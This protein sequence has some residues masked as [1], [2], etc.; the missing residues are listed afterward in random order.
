MHVCTH[1]THQLTH[2][3]HF[4]HHFISID[5]FCTAK[6][7]SDTILPPAMLL[8]NSVNATLGGHH[9]DGGFIN[10]GQWTSVTSRPNDCCYEQIRMQGYTTNNDYVAFY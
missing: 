9:I 1:E 10:L 3:F 5:C 4:I 2:F 8:N 6:N 7:T